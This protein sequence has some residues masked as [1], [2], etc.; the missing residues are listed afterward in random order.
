MYCLIDANDRFK[1]HLKNGFEML[2]LLLNSC[3]S[4]IPNEFLHLHT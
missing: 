4:A 1:D 2:S 3:L